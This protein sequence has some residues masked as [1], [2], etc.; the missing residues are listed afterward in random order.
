MSGKTDRRA[1]DGEKKLE[2]LR[3]H[4]YGRLEQLG[5]RRGDSV[6]LALSG[7]TDSLALLILLEQAAKR[8]WMGLTAAHLDHA[9][10]KEASARDAE[11][12]REIC[13][14]R[15]IP[16]IVGRL[17]PEEVFAL[18]RRGGS[19]EDAMRRLRYGF[20]CRQA[21][22]TGASWI[23]TG[24][25]RQDQAETVLFRCLR[26]M[27]WRS[28]SGIP[29]RRMAVIRPLLQISRT[30][31]E[32]VCSVAGETPLEDFTNEDMSLTRNRIRKMLLPL[33]EE[34][35]HPDTSSLLVRI[36]RVSDRLVR[37]EGRLLGRVCPGVVSLSEREASVEELLSVPP[38]LL[39]GALH[40]VL[41]GVGTRRPGR[42][43]M[44][45][46]RTALERGGD[47]QLALPEWFLLRIRG[48]RI[49]LLR[50]GERRAPDI[51]ERP[52]KVPGRVDLG[53][54]GL[55]ITA[56]HETLG[57]SEPLP[58]GKRV[59]VHA[60]AVRPPLTVRGRRPGDRFW[61]LGQSQPKKLKEFLIDR[62]VPRDRRVILPMVLD[63]SGR[64]LWVCGVEIAHWARIPPGVRTQ[65]VILEMEELERQ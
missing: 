59:A 39:E 30:E 29:E 27:D 2:K 8:G 47:S 31:L 53:E 36:S 3:S 50:K 5:V 25:Q 22:S 49:T 48:G 37:I 24:H 54:A 60:G 28:L 15:G 62:K 1:G 55:R 42:R 7:G 18:R 38:Q 43:F 11:A 34:R 26:S 41:E 35:F 46:F 65:A 10:R 17:D 6:L 23:L 12:V 32:E 16:V 44:N 20:L 21:L 14:R 19:L 4:V 63:A 45:D 40:R 58:R 57:N 61:P 51:R 33:L 52:L 9:V 56:F 13:R 64:I